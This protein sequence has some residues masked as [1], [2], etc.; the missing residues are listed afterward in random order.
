MALAELLPVSTAAATSADFS[1]TAG[2][3]TTLALKSTTPLGATSNAGV[4]FKNASG[5]Y[6]P[7]G[8]LTA[9]DPVKVLSAVGTFR[10]V[11]DAAAV[12][13]GVDT[14]T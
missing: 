1:N 3:T 6:T 7:F 11:K 5:T 8:S 14:Q 12:A 13:Y 2:S 9:S 4:E 10:V